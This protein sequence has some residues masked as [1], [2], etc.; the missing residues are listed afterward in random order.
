MLELILDVETKKTFEEVGGYFPE[1]LGVSF[2]GACLRQTGN[3]QGE[4]L[5]FF[6][7]AIGSLTSKGA[8]KTLQG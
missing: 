5:S 7:D 3:K 6:E 8:T 4:L 2:V 1:K